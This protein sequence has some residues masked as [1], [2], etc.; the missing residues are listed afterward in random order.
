MYYVRNQVCVDDGMVHGF[1]Y[2]LTLN[3]DTLPLGEFSKGFDYNADVN[4]V[5][6]NVATKTGGLLGLRI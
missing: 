2:I 5:R 3:S 6:L 4:P 1:Q